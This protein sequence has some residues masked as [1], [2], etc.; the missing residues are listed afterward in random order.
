MTARRYRW[1]NGYLHEM[2]GD[3]LTGT[4]LAILDTRSTTYTFWCRH[5]KG[6]FDTGCERYED[7]KK[8]VEAVGKLEGWL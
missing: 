1:L 5:P 2:W 6:E 7:A 8:V 3:R 4:T